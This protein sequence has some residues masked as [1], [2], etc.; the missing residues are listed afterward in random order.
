MPSWFPLRIAPQCASH[1]RGLPCGR[2]GRLEAVQR[3]QGRGA[4]VLPGACPGVSGAGGKPVARRIQ[5]G[6]FGD[7]YCGQKRRGTHVMSRIKAL[8][9]SWAIPCAG[10]R[11]YSASYRK[12]WL[13]KLSEPIQRIDAFGRYPAWDP[14]APRSSWRNPVSTPPGIHSSCPQCGVISKMTASIACCDARQ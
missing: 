6:S 1:C 3:D 11:V 9:R 5:P 13:E 12:Q 10:Q 4:L 14:F 2:G 7:R 8:Y